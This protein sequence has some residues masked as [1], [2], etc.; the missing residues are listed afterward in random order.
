MIIE[1]KLE[2][3][4]LHLPDAPKPGGVYVPSR[5][6]GNLVYISGQ[7]P[8]IGGKHQIVGVLGEDLDIEE[9]KK[10]AQLCALNILSALKAEIGDLDQV[11]RFIQVI[12]FV[13]SG[14]GFGSQPQVINGASEL[15]K[16]LYG[17]DGLATRLAIG[18]NEIP[19]GAAVEILAVVEVK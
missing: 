9:G 15:F 1:K 17:D 4:G 3:M 12:G 14:K 19:G 16:E 11:S 18:T 7:T 10:A 8:T 2:S 5:R 6:T 13:R